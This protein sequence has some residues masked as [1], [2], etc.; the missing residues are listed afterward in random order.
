ME[1]KIIFIMA[2]F[3]FILGLSTSLAY[4]RSERVSANN[5]NI[6]ISNFNVEL[7]NDINS[8]TMD[9]TYPVSDGEGLLN[10]PVT[11]AIKN[12]GS[13]IAKYNVNLVD[14][15]VVSTL[16]NTDVRY[17]LKRKIGDG[18]QEVIALGNLTGD[19]LLDTGIIQ[20]N[21]T[22]TYELVMWIDINS[23]P[24]NLVFA[25]AIEVTGMQISS[26]DTSGANYPEL[27]NNMVPIYYDQTSS[28]EGVWRKADSKNLDV[29]NQWFDYNNF[30]WA[31][32]ATL[33]NSSTNT[34]LTL[35]DNTTSACSHET[36]MRDD[37]LNAP[38]GTVIPM[39][40][41]SGMYVWIPR[42][43]YTIFNG[44]NEL[45]NEQMINISFEHGKESTGTVTCQDN[46]LSTPSSNSSQTCTDKKGSIVNKVS[47]YTHPAFTF[48]KEELTGFWIGK[49]EVSTDDATCN[50]TASSAN[51][52]KTDLNILVKPGEKS[53]R[54][55]T[56]SNLFANIRKMESFGNIHGFSQSEEA[57][58]WLDANNNL[59]GIIAN[60]N[61]NYDIHM[62]KNVE[63]GAV[64]YLSQSRYGK[65]G[66]SV[67]TGLYKEIYLN[68][69]SS[70]LTGYSGLSYNTSGSTTN[71]AAYNDLTD[72]GSGKGYKGAGASSTGTIYG[73]YDLSGGVGEYVM[74]SQV[75]SSKYFSVNSAGT[76]STTIY[77]IDMYYDKYSYNSSSYSSSYNV[78]P[79][80]RGK[81]GDAT[82]EVAKAWSSAGKWNGDYNYTPTGTS[83]YW[84]ARGGYT[85]QTSY[86]GVFA[87]Y[88][89]NGGANQYYGSRPILTIERATPW[90]D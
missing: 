29:N 21:E 87:S 24:N 7:I 85:S 11:F 41:I 38:V 28:T 33:N 45:T 69:N 56:I 77:P 27:L 14:K 88:Y 68:N 57:T 1:K 71:T 86:A 67:Y 6:T 52:N 48:G 74:G 76:W 8:V 49:F 17:Q 37:Y 20:V 46:I 78:T 16:K 65:Y 18:T 54:Y 31:N 13:M 12:N 30:M 25:K 3:I 47:S 39:N 60:D 55:I 73:V 19:G 90:N 62:I 50:G 42:F 40:D 51:C 63:W 34:E 43:K 35:S 10:T 44:N 72:Q 58:T 36:C 83:Y 80:S 89:V 26:L 5:A 61:N 4:L 75:N 66:N 23:N 84:F 81:L 15:D 64:S 32:A 59:T 22:I 79:N 53:L 9:K 2:S 82:K 70:Y